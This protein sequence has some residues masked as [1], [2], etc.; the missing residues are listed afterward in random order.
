MEF[1][2][3]GPSKPGFVEALLGHL[4]FSVLVDR[5]TPT[6]IDSFTGVLDMESLALDWRQHSSP[7]SS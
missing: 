7:S 4:L 2:A 1:R 6:I 5:T 3:N